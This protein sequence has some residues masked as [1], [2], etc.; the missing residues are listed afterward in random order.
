MGLDKTKV[1]DLQKDV[2]TRS[3]F[4]DVLNGKTNPS[5]AAFK[6]CQGGTARADVVVCTAQSSDEAVHD[7]QCDWDVYVHAGVQSG[8][9]QMNHNSNDESEEGD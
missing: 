7:I 8:G 6:G 4:S 5:Y 1:W 3:P 9:W 2:G